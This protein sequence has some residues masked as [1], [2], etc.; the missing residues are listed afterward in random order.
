[1][2]NIE[3]MKS[4]LR[5]HV[6]SLL[7]EKGYTGKWPHFRRELDDCLELISFST[8]KWGGSFTVEVSAIF[9][10]SENKN[11]YSCW[12]ELPEDQLVVW[13][14]EKRYRLKGMY[15]GWFYYRDLYR[16]F[17]IGLGIIYIPAT[18]K[19]GEEFVPPK[20]YKLVRRFNEETALLIC[21][22]VNK[23]LTKAFKWLEKFEKKMLSENRSRS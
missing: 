21:D 1:M 17:L 16:R 4:Y 22:E 3:I 10:N 13:Y 12:N 23:Q 14:T 6:F 8:N 2:T 7:Y 18:E 11:Y 20:G 5:K 15:D 19:K 9:P